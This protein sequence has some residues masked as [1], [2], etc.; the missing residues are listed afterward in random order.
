MF[1]VLN[2]LHVQ[3]HSASCLTLSHTLEVDGPDLVERI[4][5][6]CD[7]IVYNF[8]WCIVVISL[9]KSICPV[10]NCLTCSSVSVIVVGYCA[11]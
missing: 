1:L 10:R 3:Y 9:F 11:I 6:R 8:L 5:E 7:R 2:K 4:S